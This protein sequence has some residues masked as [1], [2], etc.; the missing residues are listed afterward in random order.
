MINNNR[1]LEEQAPEVLEYIRRYRR[2]TKTDMDIETGRCGYYLVF[3]D[4]HSASHNRTKITA[5]LLMLYV[6]KLWQE[7]SRRY[8]LHVV[9][10]I[11]SKYSTFPLHYSSHNHVFL[12]QCERWSYKYLNTIPTTHGQN[13]SKQKKKQA[14]NLM[15]VLHNAT[16]TFLNFWIFISIS[17]VLIGYY[18]ISGC[19]LWEPKPGEMYTK[20]NT[21]LKQGTTINFRVWKLGKFRRQYTKYQEEGSIMLFWGP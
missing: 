10:P 9:V 18:V 8:P 4:W 7:R 5:S 12:T 20:I 1:L 15:L 13:Y 3:S 16:H 21:H 14:K 2:D 11:P 17:H 6:Q 19:A